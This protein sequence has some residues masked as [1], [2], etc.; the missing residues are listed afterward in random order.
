MEIRKIEVGKPYTINDILYQTASADLSKQSKFILRQFS[1]FLEENPTITIAIQGHTDNE[2]NADNN[3]ALSQRRAEGV[4]D[5]LI[6]L[7]IEANR[8]EA[9]GFGQT[10]PKVPN[11][12]AEN[13]AKNRRTDFVIQNL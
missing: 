5:Y 3:L 1:R 8:L 13:K 10:Q 12:S 7:G 2:G 11:S 9:K 6:S 4:R